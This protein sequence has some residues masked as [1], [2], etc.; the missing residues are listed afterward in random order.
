MILEKKENEIEMGKKLKKEFEDEKGMLKAIIRTLAYCAIADLYKYADRD[1]LGIYLAGE[2]ASGKYR[3]YR[4]LGNRFFAAKTNMPADALEQFKAIH[5]NKNIAEKF[6]ADDCAD[7]FTIYA[8]FIESCGK[9][10]IKYPK[11]SENY[12]KTEKGQVF[13]Q[14]IW[15]YYEWIAEEKRRIKGEKK[16]IRGEMSGRE[17]DG[18][19]RAMPRSAF[20]DHKLIAGQMLGKKKGEQLDEKDWTEYESRVKEAK[21]PHGKKRVRR[22]A[23]FDEKRAGQ[24]TR[25]LIDIDESDGVLPGASRWKLM[26]Q[27][28][29][30][31]IDR[32]FGLMEFGADISGTTTDTVGV[33]EALYTDLLDAVPDNVWEDILLLRP[34]VALLP[35]A[36]MV[37]RGHHTALEIAYPLTRN[38]YID[39]SIG[40]YTSLFPEEWYEIKGVQRQVEYDLNLEY[41]AR[42]TKAKQFSVKVKWIA[43]K[44]FG[45]LQTY[46]YD[47]RNHRIAIHYKETTG[48]PEGAFV[49]EKGIDMI[50]FRNAATLTKNT[51]VE[52]YMQQLYESLEEYRYPDYNL[53]RNTLT[54]SGFSDEDIENALKVTTGERQAK[55]RQLL[56]RRG[57]QA[58]VQKM[59]DKWLK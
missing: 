18:K 8:E 38:D 37:S 33:I 57:H 22:E 17:P 54:G 58:E 29:I 16:I 23:T 15:S 34:I 42:E 28:A 46:E 1:E 6:D 30:Y 26:P 3:F 55:T 7:V 36:T 44:I 48:K 47:P 35:I 5:G 20:E 40:Y 25:Q 9:Q 53:V 27:S 10:P 49:M 11:S 4:K 45:I 50:R 13:K 52:A 21:I 59:L 2:A 12:H 31:Q 19:L 14:R 43:K 24:Q 56:K 51:G 32:M 41:K 39:Y